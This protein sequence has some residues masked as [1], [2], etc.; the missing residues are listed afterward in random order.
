MPLL[1]R[2]FLDR[3]VRSRP[4]IVDQ[5]VG[6]AELVLGGLDQRRAAFRRRDIAGDRYGADAIFIRDPIRFGFHPVALARC[7]HEMGA[8][9]GEPLGYRETDA[10]AS[11]SDDRDFIFQSQIHAST[12]H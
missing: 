12:P 3:L 8:L 6:A 2:G 7:E 9:G 4:G 5:D 11:A 10:D 1:V